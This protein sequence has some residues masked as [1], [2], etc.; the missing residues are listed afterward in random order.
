MKNILEN[1][2]F[3]NYTVIFGDQ[4][5]DEWL[6]LREGVVITGSNAKKV[7]GTNSAYMYELLAQA[8]TD[9]KPKDISDLPKIIHGNENEPVA[10]KEY[11]KFT[12]NK[13]KEVAFVENGRVGISPDGLI[14]KKDKI[15][16]ILEIKCPDTVTHI[17]YLL[18]GKIPAEHKDQIIHAFIVCDDV[19]ELD[20]VSYDNRFIF[21]PLFI[22]TI[23]RSDL[24]V[25][26]EATKI[27]Y[28]KFIE[29]YDENYK[30]L[31]L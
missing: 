24:F 23:K 28:K 10:R 29:K 27:K 14:F 1:V 25:D 20:F 8:T 18:E 21:N 6:K 30:K 12:G 17:R 4:K 13:V 7:N 31:I 5:T 3:G 19:D 16:K 15:K 11:E 9:W 26:I 2:T 22:K